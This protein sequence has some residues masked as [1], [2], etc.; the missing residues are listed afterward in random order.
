MQESTGTMRNK[1]ST[2]NVRNK[3]STGNMRNKES[4]G[5]MRNKESTGNMRNR[6]RTGNMRNKESTGNMRNRE[7]TGN[8][9]NKEST[10]NMRNKESTGNMRNKESTGNM[11]NR[12]RTG[13]VREC[14]DNS[15][16]NKVKN[17]Y[18]KYVEYHFLRN[19]FSKSIKKNPYFETNQQKNVIRLLFEKLKAKLGEVERKKEYA[20][21]KKDNMELTVLPDGSS[22]CHH[23]KTKPLKDENFPNL[24]ILFCEKRKI[25][26][27][28][29]TPAYSYDEELEIV[30]ICFPWNENIH[31]MFHLKHKRDEMKE[32]VDVIEKLGRPLQ[33]NHLSCIWCELFLKI[34]FEAEM[35]KV[36]EC[37]NYIF[38]S[39]DFSKSD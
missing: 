4:T 33:I 18:E 8:M 5:N 13:T 30:E 12:E 29:F 27:D 3:E 20:L 25:H 36:N 32:E 14:K 19:F 1:E 31:I 23:I 21:Y 38:E 15:I 6:E 28:I 16:L 7:R 24:L 17:Y 37:V 10:G 26:N 34:S 35:E 22:F 11:R 39:V 2:G 9:R